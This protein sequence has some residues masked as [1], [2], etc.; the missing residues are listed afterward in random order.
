MN[1]LSSMSPGMGNGCVNKVQENGDKE[2][3][4]GRKGE[5]TQVAEQ[6]EDAEQAVGAA[7]RQIDE[8]A[9]LASPAAALDRRK[10]QA[11]ANDREGRH[12]RIRSCLRGNRSRGWQKRGR[13][14]PKRPEQ[15]SMT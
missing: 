2:I 5:T 1:S 7:Q 13:W 3:G 11:I 6:I 4:E 10:E 9:P 14:P 8:T 12:N 15:R